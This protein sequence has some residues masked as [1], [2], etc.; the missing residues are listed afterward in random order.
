MVARHPYANQPGK[1]DYGASGSFLAHEDATFPPNSSQAGLDPYMTA[2]K[3]Y[4]GA[5]GYSSGAAAA[6]RGGKKKWLIIGAVVAAVVILAAVLGG[7]LGSRASSSNANSVDTSNAADSTTGTSSGSSDASGTSSDA[8]S[9]TTNS[10]STT[11]ETQDPTSIQELEAWDW[12]QDHSIGINLGNWLVLEKWMNQ[13]WW[14]QLGVNSSV[15]EWTFTEALGDQAE[16]V[17]AEHWNTWVTEDD[18]ELAFQHGVNMI[19]IPVGFWA[20]IPTSDEIEDEPYCALCGQK[21]QMERVMEYAYNRSMRVII[22]IHGLPGSQNG[23]QMS[24]HLTENPKFFNTPVNLNRSVETVRAAMEWIAG[25]TYRSTVAAIETGNEFRPYTDEQYAEL[26]Q[27]Y[28]DCY[29][30]IQASG[31]PVTH[32]IHHAYAEDKVASG[33][34]I[35]YWKDFATARATSPPS[36]AITAHPYPG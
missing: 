33:N 11:D 7:V 32:F 24:G 31:Y 6:R 29:D 26:E 1:D 28:T 12:S 27:F 20:F 17:L 3:E 35:D 16:E 4:G 8:G 34:A 15:D 36:L 18:I 23:E 14:V 30:V 10:T 21:E 19:R 9:S 13:D 22:D 25:T 2:S 5:G